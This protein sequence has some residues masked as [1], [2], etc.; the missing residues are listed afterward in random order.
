MED[1]LLF[2]RLCESLFVMKKGEEKY[3][4]KNHSK[5]NTYIEPEESPYT[6][7]HTQTGIQKKAQGRS[8]V[9]EKKKHKTLSTKESNT[10]SHIHTLTHTH[11]QI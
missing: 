9:S 4:T 11:E 10:A 3:K 5:R 8:S 7:I 6:H 1:K 2:S